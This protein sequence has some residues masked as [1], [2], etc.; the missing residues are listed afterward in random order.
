MDDMTEAHITGEMLRWARERR[1]LSYSQLASQ[2]KVSVGQIQQWEDGAAFPSFAKAEAIA[3]QLKIPFGFLFL[4]TPPSDKSPIP[5]YRTIKGKQPAQPSPNLLSVI[6]R[7]R[8]KQDWYR[9]FA[10]ENS[11]QPLQLV[12]SFSLKSEAIE[13]ARSIR[14]SLFLDHE[15]RSGISRH[16][17]FLTKLS[18][19]AQDAGVLVMRNGVSG[20]GKESRLSVAEFRGFALADPLAPIVFINSRD[21]YAAQVFTLIHELAHIWINQSGVSNADPVDN[22]S[23]NVE[24]FCNQVAGA[25]LMPSHEFAEAWSKLQHKRGFAEVLSKVFWVS[26]LAVI[27]RA[28]ELSLISDEEFYRLVRIEK[29]KSYVAKKGSG[30][31]PTSTTLARNSRR[32][33]DAVLRAVRTNR[34]V[35]NDAAW[36]LG[37]RRGGLNVLLRKSFAG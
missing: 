24:T 28:F 26:P 5:D 32:L 12:G 10:E 33:V 6:N 27:V 2:T 1:G 23:E 31:N 4:S 35:H 36:L 22:T 18:L 34:L 15:S 9:E 16:T 3:R 19:A 13:V 21:A 25:V 7:T 17:E 29:N 37:V 20:N 30:G 14:K 11:Q 8:S